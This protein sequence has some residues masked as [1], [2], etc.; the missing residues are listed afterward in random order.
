MLTGLKQVFVENYIDLP[1]EKVDVVEE[2]QAQ[3]DTMEA[4]LNE[5]IEENVELQKSVGTYIKNGIV[6]EIA[7][8]LSL[9]Q[10]EKLS[11]WRKLLS[12]KMKSLS[13]RRSLPSVNRISLQNLK[14]LRSLRMLKSR[15]HLLATQWQHMPKRSPVGANNFLPL[16]TYEY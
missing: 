11:P 9:S 10:R 7:E 3:L 1:E 14:R 6:T 15:T 16:L 2:I 5:S 13:V 8:G 4:K 12:L